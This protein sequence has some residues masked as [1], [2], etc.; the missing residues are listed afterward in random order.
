MLRATIEQPQG[1]AYVGHGLAPLIVFADPGDGDGDG[2][3]T[4]PTG[5]VEPMALG[6]VLTP[7][8]WPSAIHGDGRITSLDLQHVPCASDEVIDWSP[9]EVLVFISIPA[10]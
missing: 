6:E 3:C 10:W 8:S 4:Y 9:H 7:Y 5:A 2:Q 1:D